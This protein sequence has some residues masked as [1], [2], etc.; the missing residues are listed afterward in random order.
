MST[1][2]QLRIELGQVG[3][4][5][6]ADAVELVAGDAVGDREH[7]LAVAR[8][9]GLSFISSTAV[10]RSSYFHSLRGRLNF[11]SV[12]LD[13]QRVLRQVAFRVGEVFVE[14][15]DDV[16][17]AEHAPPVAGIGAD[18]GIDARLASAP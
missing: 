18:V 14:I 6:V 1:G 16:Q 15:G 13:R 5:L 7:L 12:V 10:A 17:G 8:T 4:D 3:A 11:S 9:S 2:L